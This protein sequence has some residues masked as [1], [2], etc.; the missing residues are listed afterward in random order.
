MLDIE[1]HATQ[2]WGSGK[3]AM[4]AFDFMR[5]E[6]PYHPRP[7]DGQPVE[8]AE[9]EEMDTWETEVYAEPNAAAHVY[10]G[11]H[12]GRRGGFHRG[13]HPKPMGRHDPGHGSRSGQP[14][15]ESS[16]QGGDRKRRK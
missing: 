3:L 4:A 14:G 11:G 12:R 16:S 5:F 13:R 10:R 1:S 2:A 7:A 8:V 9:A 6:V 15:G